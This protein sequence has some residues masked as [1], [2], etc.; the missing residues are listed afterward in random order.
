L[1]VVNK[2]PT[3]TILLPAPLAQPSR[4]TCIIHALSFPLDHD[5]IVFI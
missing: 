4:R 3:S 5:T 1:I 2:A